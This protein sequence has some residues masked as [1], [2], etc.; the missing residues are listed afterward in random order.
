ML[1]TQD[2]GML[3]LRVYLAETCLGTFCSNLRT[4]QSPLGS[5]RGDLIMTHFLGDVW[6]EDQTRD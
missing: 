4:V 1:H 2:A 6:E 5:P 3:V